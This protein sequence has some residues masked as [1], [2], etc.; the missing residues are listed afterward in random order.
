MINDLSEKNK[1]ENHKIFLNFIEL[2]LDIGLILFESN[3]LKEIFLKKIGIVEF[4]TPKKRSINNN[5]R[6]LKCTGLVSNQRVCDSHCTSLTITL[7]AHSQ[8]KRY[9]K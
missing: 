7:T 9:L 2:I 3:S 5:K 4:K 6:Q 8:R 1:L